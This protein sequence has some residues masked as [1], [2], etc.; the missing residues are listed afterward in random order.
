ME[1]VTKKN[2]SSSLSCVGRKL[3]RSINIRAL[4]VRES[5]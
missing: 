1:S 5:H 4:Y 2:V 3:M